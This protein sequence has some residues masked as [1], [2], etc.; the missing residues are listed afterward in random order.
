MSGSTVVLLLKGNGDYQEI[1]LLEIS[2]KIIESI[3]NRQIAS[4]VNFHN[5]LHGF[6]ARIDTGTACVEAKLL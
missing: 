2:W 3:M 5:A 1:G 6:R 4:K